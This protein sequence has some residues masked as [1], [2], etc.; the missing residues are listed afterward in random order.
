M[1]LIIK[2]FKDG[3]RFVVVF[4]NLDVSTEDCI[5]GLLS[6]I[7][8]KITKEAPAVV[9]PLPKVEEEA[10]KIPT[11]EETTPGDTDTPLTKDEFVKRYMG[12]DPISYVKTLDS[13]QIHDFFRSCN[14]LIPEKLRKK[15]IVRY[16]L[17]EWDEYLLSSD[18]I[19][20]NGIANIIALLTK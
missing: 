2:T 5:V 1:G 11:E 18:D 4:E 6:G 13:S 7:T 20:R 19:L 8:G 14:H 10:I 17:S 12:K 3:D 9:E 16:G 15:L